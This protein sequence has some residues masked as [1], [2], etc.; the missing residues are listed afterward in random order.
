MKAAMPV[1]FIIALII[2]VIVVAVLAY[3]FISSGIK[4]S[5]IGTE[6]ECTARKTEWCVTQRSDA[7]AKVSLVCGSVPTLKEWCN[8]CKFIPKW[9]PLTGSCPEK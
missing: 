6:A 7:E 5:D 2:G 9:R 4:G 1:P 8:Y 3:W